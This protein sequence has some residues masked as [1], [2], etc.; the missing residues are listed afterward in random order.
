[1]AIPRKSDEDQMLFCTIK[2]IR[3]DSHLTKNSTDFE[4]GTYMYGTEI[5][6][7]RFQEF[8]NCWISKKRTLQTNILEGRS[9]GKEILG[10]KFS[11]IP[12]R[13]YNG[14]NSTYCSPQSSCFFA[15]EVNGRF[16]CCNEF[17]F[18]LQWSTRTHNLRKQVKLHE[19][20]HWAAT[21]RKFVGD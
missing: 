14:T 17:I 5:S 13:K 8:Q 4:T 18:I 20:C 2:N 7:G 9:N 15:L 11:K 21:W 10:E 19:I 12:N 6:W 16:N 1:M 3:G